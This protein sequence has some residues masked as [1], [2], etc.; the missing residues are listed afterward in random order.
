MNF[1]LHKNYKSFD[2]KDNFDPYWK[3]F[4]ETLFNL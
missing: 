3:D 1:V 2:K 4:L